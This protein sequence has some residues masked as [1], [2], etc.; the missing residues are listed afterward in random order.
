[1]EGKAI[2]LKMM[3]KD[4]SSLAVAGTMARLLSMAGS[5]RK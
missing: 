4:P 5:K 1:M 2:K 3:M